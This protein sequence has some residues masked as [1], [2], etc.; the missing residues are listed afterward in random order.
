M[1][2]DVR[3]LVRWLALVRVQR[4][5]HSCAAPEIKFVASNHLNCSRP[6]GLL[7][8]LQAGWLTGTNAVGC[9]LPVCELLP[10]EKAQLEQG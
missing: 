7:W 9:K 8:M 6:L 1:T 10:A 4:N 3:L 5:A 2:F